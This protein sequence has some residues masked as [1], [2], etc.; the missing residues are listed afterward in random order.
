M[1]NCEILKDIKPTEK[2]TF[3]KDLKEK[4]ADLNQETKKS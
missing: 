3:P 2:N 1:S 4:K